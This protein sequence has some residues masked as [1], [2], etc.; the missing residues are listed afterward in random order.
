M[1]N[2]SVVDAIRNFAQSSSSPE[3]MKETIQDMSGASEYQDLKR[4]AVETNL[5]SAKRRATEVGQA[6]MQLMTMGFEAVGAIPE[7]ATADYTN[8]IAEEAR[9]YAKTPYAK[10]GGLG[11]LLVDVAVA[12]PLIALNAP[13]AATVRGGVALG[14]FEGLTRP[15]YSQKDAN[16]LNPERMKN[17]AMSSLA[18]AGGA[19]LSNR[20]LNPTAVTV[21]QK[22]TTAP[23]N[24][25]ERKGLEGIQKE[26]AK[27][28][29]DAAKKLDTFVTPAEA[30]KDALAIE[31]ESGLRLFGKAKRDLNTILEQREAGLQ[32]NI[33][34][35]VAG[36]VPEGTDAARATARQFSESAY[37]TPF[38][39]VAEFAAESKTLQAAYDAIRGTGRREFIRRSG[40]IIDIKPNTVGD[41]HLMRLYVDDLIKESI[42]KKA[43]YAEFAQAR[44][45][46]LAMADTFAPEYA[47]SRNINQ[48]ILLQ[49]KIINTLDT[50][51]KNNPRGTTSSFYNNYLEN[52]AKTDKFMAELNNITDEAVRNNIIRN[53]EVI[54]PVLRAINDSPLDTALKSATKEAEARAAGVGGARGI[55]LNLVTNVTDG[56]L[57][58]ELIGFITSPNWIG[59]FDRLAVNKSQTQKNDILLKLFYEYVGKVAPTTAASIQQG[60]A[61]MNRQEQAQQQQQPAPTN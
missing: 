61:A 29:T 39:L 8:Q 23:F 34:D 52:T 49:D 19:Y 4:G 57:D 24:M 2:E 15:A 44:N 60:K 36:I 6:G 18:G 1:S 7:G 14:A 37:N 20:L 42:A 21:Q 31:R 48:R 25:I 55:L 16:L 51:K 5:I 45:D 41:L 54:E 28:A 58:N 33:N 56:L 43:G 40:G 22:M 46:L 27:E 17:V 9:A 10:E 59:R 26:A 12:L 13:L 50:A 38:P 3:N 11:Q 35:I 53:V 32:S 47:L 30:T